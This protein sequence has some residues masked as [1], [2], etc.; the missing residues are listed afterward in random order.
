[1]AS[2]IIRGLNW[3]HHKGIIHRDLKTA[4]MLVRCVDF[5][6]P[7]CSDWALCLRWTRP[8]P[9]RSLILAWLTW[10]RAR[11]FAI[12]T[13][14]TAT[15]ARLVTCECL[16]G[17]R[18][19]ADIPYL[20][21][22]SCGA[23]HGLTQGARGDQQRTVRRKLRRLLL[24]HGRGSLLSFCRACLVILSIPSG[25]LRN[26]HGLLSVQEGRLHQVLC[27]SH[28]LFSQSSRMLW[29]RS[30]NTNDFS[31]DIKV[32]KRPKIPADTH[33]ALSKMIRCVL[34]LNLAAGSV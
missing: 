33:P 2:D 30:R 18:A 7:V 1:M 13:A 9:S 28:L 15:L 8:T 3:L 24:W 22:L 16:I 27:H 25:A 31:D 20:R 23:F 17:C 12:L 29:F 6:R 26:D 5:E 34:D 14:S 21:R 32:G 11:T 4:N 10:P 19:N